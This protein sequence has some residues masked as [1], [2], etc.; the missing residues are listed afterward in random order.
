MRFGFAL[1]IAP[2]F[3]RWGCRADGMDDWYKRGMLW[4]NN[5]ARAVATDG[6]YRWFYEGY[7]RGVA[8]QRIGEPEEVADYTIH[9]P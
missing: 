7:Y 9:L 4:C 6:E 8:E 5:D 2:S 3:H 1:R